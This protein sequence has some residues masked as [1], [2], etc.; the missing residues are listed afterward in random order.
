MEL[1]KMRSAEIIDLTSVE[2]DV[3]EDVLLYS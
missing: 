3:L 1:M 2:E